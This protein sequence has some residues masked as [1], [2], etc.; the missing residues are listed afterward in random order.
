ML[1]RMA[2][3]AYLSWRSLLGTCNKVYKS[4][5]FQAIFWFFVMYSSLLIFA[6][7][8]LILFLYRSVLSLVLKVYY[9]DKY[10]LASGPQAVYATIDSFANVLNITY[11]IYVD[12]RCDIET[13]RKTISTRILARDEKGKQP[14][15]LLLKS[16]TQK[17]G[18]SCLSDK[19]KTIDFNEHVRFCPGADDPD[20]VYA[21]HEYL[22]AVSKL[23][24]NLWEESKPKWE[25][26]VTPQVKREGSEEISTAIAV[27]FQH[28]YVDGISLAQFVR[29]CIVD[30]PAPKLI[31]DPVNP[32]FPPLPLYKKILLG[33]QVFFMGPYI[34]LRLFGNDYD[35]VF[36]E[37]PLTGGNKLIGRTKMNISLEMMRRIRKFHNCTTQ[38]VL[39]SAFIGSF[40]KMA[41]RKDI[42]LPDEAIG[43]TMLASFPYPDEY[44][45][46]NTSFAYEPLP[47]NNNNPLGRLA[48]MEMCMKAIRN[49]TYALNASLILLELLGMYP[50]ALIRQSTNFFKTAYYVSNVPG[51]QGSLTI[52]GK[53]VWLIFGVGPL[54]NRIRYHSGVSV[55]RGTFQISLYIERSKIISNR[56]E[57]EEWIEEYEKEIQLL[58]AGVRAKSV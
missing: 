22:D 43:A 58:D 32:R 29:N 10:I 46:N 57:L 40:Q 35:P 39:N 14:Y 16:T 8:I 13:L 2:G 25:L 26:L 17:F 11:F 24:D 30:Q 48:E 20:R 31:L 4:V 21:E 36:S 1:N 55:Y 23:A 19:S 45:N 41:K 5:A 51:V 7:P 50:T 28:L 47:I 15:G 38:A 34:S 6:I 52:D 53:N 27:K 37:G 42:K 44:T 56:E 9:K 3:S 54:L 12:G 33:L 18:F 49:R